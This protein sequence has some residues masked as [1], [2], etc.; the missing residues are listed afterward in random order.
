MFQRI[1]AV[2]RCAGAQFDPV[3]VEAF[4]EVCAA[5]HPAAVLR[6]S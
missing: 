2:R 5:H 3:A 6:R 1:R 4:H